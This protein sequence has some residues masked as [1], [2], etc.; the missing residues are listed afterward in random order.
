MRDAVSCIFE[1]ERCASP[2]EKRSNEPEAGAQAARRRA[3]RSL[4]VTP[5]RQR[6]ARRR[7]S[8]SR[9]IGRRASLPRRC[10][11]LRQTRAVP[12]GRC[13]SEPRRCIS[14]RRTRAAPLRTRASE[15]R[16]CISRR[17]SRPIRLGRCASEPG[18]CAPAPDRRP[19]RP[20]RGFSRTHGTASALSMRAVRPEAS[21]P[22]RGES[23]RRTCPMSAARSLGPAPLEGPVAEAREVTARAWPLVFRRKGRGPHRHDL[24]SRRR[25]DAA[26]TPIPRR[27]SWPKSESAGRR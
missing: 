18:R 21:N 27:A 13:A 20:R 1:L 8:R 16:R 26:S 11:S 5:A 6:R 7:E 22:P 12:S 2:V 10:V 23:A 25:S 19:A 4:S 15:P 14:L 3:S 17:R 9:T 24:A